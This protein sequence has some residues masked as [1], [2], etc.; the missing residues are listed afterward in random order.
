MASWIMTSERAGGLVVAR[1][2]AVEHQ[3]P[4]GPHHGPALGQRS[5]S[6]GPGGTLDDFH[7]DAEPGGVFNKVL[8]V[9]AVHPDSADRGVGGRNLVDQVGAKGAVR[10]NKTGGPAE[11]TASRRNGDASGVGTSSG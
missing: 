6:P 5:E 9:A 8:A 4:V 7:V 10:R 1:Q 11:T 2:A 3:P